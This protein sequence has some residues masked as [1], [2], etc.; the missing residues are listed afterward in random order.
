MVVAMALSAAVVYGVSDF[1]G[2]V[3]S[4]RTAAA[5]AVLVAQVVGLVVLAA[6]LPFLGGSPT[7]AD[8][9]W[10]AGAGVLGG[11]GMALLYRGLAAGTMSVVAPVTAV[12]AAGVPVAVGLAL[13]ERPAPTAA[14]GMAIALPAVVLLSR[15]PRLD[16]ARPRSSSVALG[17][18]AGATFGL[19]FVLLANT[20]DA[21]GLWPLLG[22]RATSIALLAGFTL[23][24]VRGGARRPHPSSW[25]ALAACGVLDM[26]A[27]VLYLLAVRQEMLVLVSTLVALYPASTVLLA[28]TLLRERLHAVQL[29]GLAG[30]ATAAVLIAS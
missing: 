13:G 20:G 17:L 14:L 22:A 23:L 19:F 15:E 1:L 18:A 21:A 25:A 29:L 11:T 26:A 27:N 12:T 28:Q 16:A 4:R 2:G 10:G 6:A 9:A 3:A 5:T 30:A 8:L 24:T 7:P